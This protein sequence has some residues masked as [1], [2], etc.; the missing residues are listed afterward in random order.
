[1]NIA[2]PIEY[3]NARDYFREAELK[4]EKLFLGNM[5]TNFWLHKEKIN[6]DFV[7]S[8]ARN[9]SDARVFIISDGNNKGFYIYSESRKI[10]LQLIDDSRHYSHAEIA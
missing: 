8:S 3:L 7:L 6:L 4:G 2:K 1:M 5:N 9:L 10:C